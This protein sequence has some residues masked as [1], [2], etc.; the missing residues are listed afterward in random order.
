MAFAHRGAGMSRVQR[1]ALAWLSMAALAA[2]VITWA[3]EAAL[4]AFAVPSPPVN[5]TAV[6]TGQT[7][8]LSW[9]GGPGT[10]V[11]T[12]YWVEAGSVAG[13]R[14]IGAWPMA[15]T[16]LL[17]PGVPDGRYF[18]R[19][20]AATIEGISG[21]SNEVDV[22]VGCGAL[23]APPNLTGSVSG[24]VVAIAWTPVPGASAYR[25]E[26]GSAPGLA[27]IA[28]V[29][30]AAT[31]LAAPVPHGA[32][33]VRVRAVGACGVGDASNE[34]VLRVGVTPPST[35]PIFG[36][37][38]PIVLGACSA[39]TH[40][41][42][43]VDGGDGFRYRSWH[44]QADPSGCVYAHEHGDDPALSAN[45]AIS[46][47]PVRFGYIGR[48]MDHEEAHEGFKVFVANPGD[49]NDEGRVNR[50]YS[51][52]VFHMGTGGPKRF[53]MPH[54]SADIRVVHPE[55]GLAAFTQLMMDTGGTGAVCDPRSPAPVKDV[56][57]LQ[58]PCKLGSAYEIWS[59]TQSV[60]YQGR[61]V[62]TAFATPA[63]FDP[64]TVL[65]PANP[66]ELVYVWDPRVSAIKLFTD[67]WSGFR[68]CDRESYAQPGYWRNAGG[69]TTFYTDA[70][71]RQVAPG[72]PH[73]LVQQIAAVDSIGA[74][75]TQDGLVQF[76]MRKS[77]CQQRAKLGLKN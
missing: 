41:T 74:P 14:D 20:R 18:V 47:S 30:T 8:A 55:F 43:V 54:H 57:Q 5:L 67:D 11:G 27:D 34:V 16:G 40:D 66:T 59:T 75:A 52:S 31:A 73:A 36:V 10:P 76:K 19:V 56:I 25:L 35:P 26:A 13:A 3:G 24:A 63:V 65:N 58:S 21:P 38:D 77:Y 44:P 69:P 9:L 37:V 46:A 71:G 72:D 12:T 1:F 48:R 49:V 60:M 64:I 45:A 23:V 22:R 62:Y 42:W 17:A 70:M 4:D 32:Y 61:A 33:Y 53:S 39:A 68:G 2:G 50:V 28:V 15:A 6:V 29:P 7:V 51:R